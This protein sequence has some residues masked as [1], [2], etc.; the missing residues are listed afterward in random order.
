MKKVILVILSLMLLVNAVS[1]Y[2]FYLKCPE[3]VT[4]GTPVKCS[5][6]S[7]FPQ[8]TTFNIVFSGSQN[9]MK[10]SG[11]IPANQA[12]MY[13]VFD[14]EGKTAGQYSIDIEFTGSET[15]RLR[16][17]SVTSQKITVVSR[18]TTTTAPAVTSLITTIPSTVKIAT[19]T[20]VPTFTPALTQEMS[21]PTTISTP[22][23]TTIPTKSMEKLIEE[24]NKKIDAQNT[25]IAEQNRKISEQNDILTQ[26]TT[27]LK[28][29]FGWK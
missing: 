11:I 7:D 6:D 24:Q 13:K 4:A 10:E 3:Q 8:G 28:N 21:V 26:M 20:T 9:H 27:Y 14:T 16:S 5:I 19:I 25:L 17:D 23:I 12:T 22:A 18:A 15:P 2:G 1:A 29:I